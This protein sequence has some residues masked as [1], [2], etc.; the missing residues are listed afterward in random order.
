MLPWS[1]VLYY[2]GTNFKVVAGGLRYANGINRSPDGSRIYVAS[3]TGRSVVV[4]QRDA[5]SGA[6]S[7]V[8]EV[9]LGTG[10]D[11]IEVDLEG[12]LWIGAH[13]KL[14]TFLSHASDPAV[15]APSQVIKITPQGNDQ[16]QVDEVFLSDGSDMSGSSVAA[17]HGNRLLIGPVMDDRF[18]DCVMSK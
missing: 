3:V 11:N 8:A 14:L 13:A 18:L 17:R 9:G 12:N 5:R 15:D 1:N 4:Y 16:F 7:E 6:L 10:P 2:D